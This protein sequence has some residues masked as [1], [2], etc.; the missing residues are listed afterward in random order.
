M[1]ADALLKRPEGFRNGCLGCPRRKKS[2]NE[3]RKD[4]VSLNM[5]RG[6]VPQGGWVDGWMD[7]APRLTF[8]RSF[9]GGFP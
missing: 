2:G 5:D 3:A 4:P 9:M 8:R 1:L 7:Q 6:E